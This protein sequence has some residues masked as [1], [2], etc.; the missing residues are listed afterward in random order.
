LIEGK[1]VTLHQTRMTK[2]GRVLIPAELR[3][4]L[5]LKEQEPL[6]IYAQDGE[7]RIVSRL[8]AIKQMQQRLAKYKVE[9]VSVVDELLQ[10]RRAEAALESDT[11]APKRPAARSRR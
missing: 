7:I 2:E 5:G 1:T 9:G 11:L 6:T 3:R 8:Q 4:S 10:E